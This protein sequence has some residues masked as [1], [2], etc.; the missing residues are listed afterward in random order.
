MLR[1][2]GVSGVVLRGGAGSIPHFLWT[3]FDAAFDGAYL[4]ILQ[5]LVLT[6]KDDL[7]PFVIHGLLHATQRRRS[8]SLELL[9]WSIIAP[10]DSLIAP[11]TSIRE[12]FVSGANGWGSSWD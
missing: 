7:A 3:A 2:A 11:M 1:V 5:A 4:H 9:R 10:Q 8:E 6:Y 12:Q